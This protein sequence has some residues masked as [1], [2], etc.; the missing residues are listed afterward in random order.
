MLLPLNQANIKRPPHRCLYRG[1]LTIT[2][3]GECQL[4]PSNLRLEQP[5]WEVIADIPGLDQQDES[6]CRCLLVSDEQALISH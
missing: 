1:V 5:G 3:E 6:N 4:V 2:S